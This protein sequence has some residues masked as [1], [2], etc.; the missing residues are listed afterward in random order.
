[1]RT[2]LFVTH[3]CVGVCGCGT[4]LTCPPSLHTT[5]TC[6]PVGQLIVAAAIID[7]MIALVILSVLESLTVAL[8]VSSILVPIVSAL[9]FLIIGGYLAIYQAPQF[10]H[11]FVLDKM[12]EQYYPKIEL[13]IMFGLLLALLPATYYC[14]SSFLMGAFLAGLVFCRSHG[15]HAIYVSQFKRILAWL[16]RIFFAASIG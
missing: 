5:F 9:C 13:G 4:F 10:I 7:D 14:K 6:R 1:M 15:L 16:M 3:V 8:T 2:L 11:R 12:E